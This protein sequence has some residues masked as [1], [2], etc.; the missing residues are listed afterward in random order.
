MKAKREIILQPGQYQDVRQVAPG[1]AFT[2]RWGD[3]WRLAFQGNVHEISESDFEIL[4]SEIDKA[5]SQAA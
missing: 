5:A 4:R 3:N 1:L 2:Q